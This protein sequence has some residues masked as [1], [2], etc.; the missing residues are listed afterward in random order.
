M[1]TNSPRQILITGASSGIGHCCALALK[2]RGYRVFATARKPEDLKALAALGLET[3]ALDLNSSASIHNAVNELLEKTNGK[4]DFL[5]NNAGYGQ[6]GAVED[7]PRD[8]IRTQFETNVFGL[9]ELTNLIIPVMRKQGQGRIINTSSI[10]GIITLPYRGAYNASKFAVEGFT[11]TLRQELYGTGIQVILIEPGPITSQFRA[12]AYA[13]YMKSIDIT[14]SHHRA[15]YE[16]LAQQFAD[17]T[18]QDPFTLPPQ[19]VAEKLI[20]ALESRKPK[21]RYYVTFPTYA[22]SFL[23]R[24]LPVRA[25]DWVLRQISDAE[26]K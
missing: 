15:N 6:P 17:E 16:K 8:I 22:L 14:H 2:A 3:I 13:A 18:V 1:I 9:I 20:H 23:K 21:I 12:N 24:L 25:M 7:L 10:L 5:F 26:L 11:D 19:A 4:L